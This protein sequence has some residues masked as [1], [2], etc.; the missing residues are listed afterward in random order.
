MFKD[1]VT[2]ANVSLVV[3]VEID[4]P[5]ASPQKMRDWHWARRYGFLQY[6]IYAPQRFSPLLRDIVVRV[7]SHTKRYIDE[8][9]FLWGGR[10]NEMATLEITGPGVFTDAIL[11]V[12]SDA[13]PSTHPLVQKS[14]DADAEFGDLVPSYSALPV[15][16]VTWAP[17]HGIKETICVDGSEAEPGNMFGGVCV[18]PVN[19]WGNGQRHSGSEGFSSS[20]ACINHR[21]GGTWKPWRQSWKQYLFG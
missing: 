1:P 4:E 8:S 13:L 2:A 14:V 5:F 19:A 6:N 9:H 12:L 7:M 10:Y 15:Q 11:D 17:F 3:G 18:L 21:F 16:R 20:H